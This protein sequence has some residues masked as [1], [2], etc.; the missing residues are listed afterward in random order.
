MASLAG[1]ADPTLARMAYAAGMANVPGDYSEHYQ[2][3]VDAH[4]ELMGGIEEIAAGIKLENDLATLEFKKAMKI[5]EDPLN[6]QMIDSDYTEMQADI[7]A[8]RE[9]WKANKG[10]KNDPEGRQDWDRRNQ[11]II[12]RH[13]QDN[14]NL[15]TLQAGIEGNLYDIENMEIGKKK[16]LTD[17]AKYQANQDKQSGIHNADATKYMK[18]HPNATPAQLWKKLGIVK[19]GVVVK[20]KD[21][22]T[23]EYTYVSKVGEDPKNNEPL[24]ELQKSSEL[25][26]YVNKDA[27]ADDTL[28]KAQALYQNR[29]KTSKGRSDNYSGFRNEDRNALEELLD[30]DMLNNPNTLKYMM[31]KKIGGEKL[32]FAEA[33]RNGKALGLTNEIIKELGATKSDGDDILTESDFATAESYE[34]V[35]N[36]ILSGKAIYQENGKNKSLDT[37]GMYLD[38]TVDNAFKTGYNTYKEKV[39]K[40]NVKTNIKTNPYG[41]SLSK[42]GKYGLGLPSKGTSYVP[43]YDVGYVTNKIDNLK[44]GTQIS[45]QGGVYTYREVDGT[46]QW[47]KNYGKGESY[48]DPDVEGVGVGVPIGTAK[49][50]AEKVFHVDDPIFTS[51]VTERETEV[52]DDETG[53]LPSDN[54]FA[55]KQAVVEGKSKARIAPTKFVDAFKKDFQSDNAVVRYLRDMNVPGLV[56]GAYQGAGKLNYP[57]NDNRKLV[58][59][60][61]AYDDV[62]LTING[63]TKLFVTDPSFSDDTEGAQEIWDW[64]YENF[65]STVTSGENTVTS[66]ENTATSDSGGNVRD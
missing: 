13:E 23:G 27:R 62:I 65:S 64:L 17:L 60:I 26:D 37:K 3:T 43:Q 48:D 39:D 33:L 19:E 6:L 54:P 34:T 16:Y 45:F 38:Y 46:T 47:W 18:D 59:P 15:G 10:F 35:V 12:G 50:M 2:S 4:K 20:F 21:P 24:F 41:L 30:T 14:A 55:D 28:V 7:T 51:I 9:E 25:L 53:L 29:L 1:K 31:H 42:K 32:S 5:F 49:D 58:E 57:D 44:S 66:G 8:Q 40:N 52:P 22:V 61:S 11:Q 56:V 36:N 63:K